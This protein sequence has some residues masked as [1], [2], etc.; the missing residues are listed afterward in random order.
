MVFVVVEV[1][2]ANRVKRWYVFLRFL[3]DVCQVNHV[4]W[5]DICVL[6]MDFLYDVRVLVVVLRRLRDHSHASEVLTRDFK[7]DWVIL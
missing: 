2:R 3:I 7:M 5:E 1:I 4:S 6:P